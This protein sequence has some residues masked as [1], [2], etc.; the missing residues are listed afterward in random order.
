MIIQGNIATDE[1]EFPRILLSQAS[2]LVPDSEY[3]LSEVKKND[4]TLYIK[5]PDLSDQRINNV[6]RIGALNRGNAKIVLF[7]ESR[8]KYCAMKDISIDP[9]AKVLEKLSSLFGAENVILK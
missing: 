5:I 8:R 9:S 3:S 7:D 2:P 6:K 4:P 1:G